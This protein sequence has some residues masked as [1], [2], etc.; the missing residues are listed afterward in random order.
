MKPKGKPLL[1]SEITPETKLINDFEI[2][3]TSFDQ[4]EQNDITLLNQ[5]VQLS[6]GGQGYGMPPLSPITQDLLDGMFTSKYDLLVKEC[7]QL[8]KPVPLPLKT[9][10]VS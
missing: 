3:T 8:Y 9:A 2:D 5:L 1:L 4:Q 10:S 6:L 7:D